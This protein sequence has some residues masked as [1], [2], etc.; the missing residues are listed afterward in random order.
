[1]LPPIIA[2]RFQRDIQA[3]LV[4]E[5]EAI[6]D[7]LGGAEKSSPARLQED[8]LL[9]RLKDWRRKSE[10]S[11]AVAPLLENARL[12]V[13][14]PSTLQRGF[15][16]L[17]GDIGVRREGRRHHAAPADWL[18]P[19]FDVPWPSLRQWYRDRFPLVSAGLLERVA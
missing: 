1:M 6:G 18:P 4:S 10:Q 14:S 8:A 17:V 19:M 7:G 13:Q 15:V 3:D 12:S 11:A 9:P 2:Q 5:L 16:L